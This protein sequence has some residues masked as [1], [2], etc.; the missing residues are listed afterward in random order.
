MGDLFDSIGK[1]LEDAGKSLEK[2]AKDTGDAVG[3]AGK[4]VASAVGVTPESSP[5]KEN[6]SSGN[7]GPVQ[8]AKPAP[9]PKPMASLF[10]SAA[11]PDS[12]K[13]SAP[14]KTPAPPNVNGSAATASKAGSATTGSALVA[15]Q[16]LVVVMVLTGRSS[17]CAG[18]ADPRAGSSH[19]I[20]SSFF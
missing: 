2:L 12:K 19:P 3:D 14:A 4:A 17:Q 18:S 10:S 8:P 7:N 1:S 9:P 6:I 20:Y 16:W 15:L 13:S 11:K 5:Q